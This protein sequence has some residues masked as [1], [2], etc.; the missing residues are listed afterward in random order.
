MSE[1]DMVESFQELSDVLKDA[2]NHPSAVVTRGEALVS[3]FD[4]IQSALSKDEIEEV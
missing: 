1:Q 3:L 4:E 2:G